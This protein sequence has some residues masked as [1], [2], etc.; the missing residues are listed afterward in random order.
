[1]HFELVRQVISETRT[2]GILYCDSRMLGYT[3]E[4]TDRRLES[5][6]EKVPGKTAIPRGHYTMRLS[7][8]TR[9]KRI[10]PEVLNVPFFTG[11]RFHGGN[12]ENDTEGCPLLG[13]RTNMSGVWECARVNKEMV[14]LMA[15][16]EARGEA[17][18][19]EV[20]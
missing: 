9:F 19:L 11:I 15:G 17:I 8:S 6:G 4:D 20:R 16:A 18:T 1:M 12:T 13:A 10:M 2:L 7:M 3:C 5:G 14:N